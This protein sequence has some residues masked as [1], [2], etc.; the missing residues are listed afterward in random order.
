MREMKEKKDNKVQKIIRIAIILLILAAV[1]GICI[2]VYPYAKMLKTPEGRMWLS[3]YLKSF[4]ALGAVIFVAL[5]TL[6][7][8]IAVLPPVQIVG[9]FMYGV[10]FGTLL[11]A[12]GVYLGNIII[13][14]VSR[15]LG[16]PLVESVVSEKNFKK[17]GFLQNE[18]KL[19][20]IL[21]ILYLIPGVPKDVITY[22]V[23]LSKIKERNFYLYVLP[24]RLPAI[25]MSTVFG[26][27][28]VSDSYV[29]LYIVIGLFI[30]T[31]IFG[32][33]YRDK[34]IAGLKTHKE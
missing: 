8:I 2:W 10:F 12:A 13:F 28:L 20:R 34:I 9:G 15:F 22:I 25:I 17:F 29:G 30:L 7:V 4:G 5:Q 31:A 6:Q 24:A 21:F 3:D 18:E 19:E 32:F 14:K 23:A 26:K 33:L 1:A 16:K 11:S 27:C